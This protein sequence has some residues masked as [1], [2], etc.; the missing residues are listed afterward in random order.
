M[1]NFDDF[2]YKTENKLTADNFPL[3]DLRFPLAL[4]FKQS[5]GEQQLLTLVQDK[6]IESIIKNP[7]VDIYKSNGFQLFFVLDGQITEKIENKEFTYLQG[8][9]F[10]LS[11]QIAHN[12]YHLSGR[13]LILD[14]SESIMQ[15][16]LE[17]LSE[18]HLT[19]PLFSHLHDFFQSDGEYQR[20]FLEFS[21]NLPVKN[22]LFR[23]LLDQIQVELSTQPLGTEF[24]QKG[25]V[26]RLLNALQDDY[27]FKLQPVKLT[28]RKEDYLVNRLITLIE[29]R[30][31]M[32]SR[33]EIAVTLHYNAEYLNRLLK[34][35]SNHTISTYCKIIRIQKAQQLLAT[36]NLKIAAIAEVLRFNSEHYFY[37]FFKKETGISPRVYRQ[38]FHAKKKH[39]SP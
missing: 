25:L 23:N 18:K 29:A 4:L 32:I 37:T 33:Q 15:A 27:Y 8:Q 3:I 19:Q 39:L 1:V 34:R 24:F 12:E 7:S 11:P 17:I 38:Q 2:S 14:I 28:A 6:N 21:S 26:L 31:G 10:L 22:K 30:H 20:S 13:L 5:V 9:G 36:T 35:H 16:I